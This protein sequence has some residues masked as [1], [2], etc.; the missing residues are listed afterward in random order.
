MKTIYIIRDN[1]SGQ[2]SPLFIESN[3]KS[4][5]RQFGAFLSGVSGSPADYDLYQL[6]HLVDDDP[7]SCPHILAGSLS[8]NTLR[9]VINGL[10]LNPQIVKESSNE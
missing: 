6:G 3:T 7:E 2:Y 4:A 5:Q 1:V 8:E 10:A 9:H